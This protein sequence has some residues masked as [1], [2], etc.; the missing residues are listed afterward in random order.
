[1]IL[2]FD[3]MVRYGQDEDIMVENILE[4]TN[5]KVVNILENITDGYFALDRSWR[6]TYLNKASEKIFFNSRENLLGKIIW[7]VIPE[8][9]NQAFFELYSTA[10]AEQKP[11]YFEMQICPEG[12]WVEVHAYPTED[13]LSVYFRDITQ[14]KRVEVA[15][16]RSEERS[17]RLLKEISRLERLQLIEKMAGC[18]SHEIRNPLT[19]VRGFLQLLSKNVEFVRYQEYFD[20]MIEELDRANAIITEYLSLSNNNSVELKL[21][22]L[23]QIIEKLLPLIQ[24]DAL[25]TDKYIELELQEVPDLPLNKSEIHQLLLNLVRNGL[26]AMFTGG[27]LTI[28]TY[29]EGEDVVL[30]VK[31]QGQGIPPSV[32]EKIGTLFFSTKDNG[33]GLGLPICYSIARRHNASITIET[34]AKGTIF[35]VKFKQQAVA[36]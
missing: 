9:I 13:G 21:L 12:D 19:T 10:I 4:V 30:A 3:E 35:L 25:M 20:L 28:K 16:R 26:E 32:L 14:R 23:N 27:C 36:N 7:E 2:S 22:N 17:A 15:L 5:R 11:V 34:S 6:F 8:H 29:T 24:A 18:I 33:T 31:D 1:M